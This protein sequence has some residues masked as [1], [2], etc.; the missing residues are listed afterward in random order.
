MKMFLCPK[1]HMDHGPETND[2]ISAEYCQKCVSEM[3]GYTLKELHEISRFTGVAAYM[4]YIPF[5]VTPLPIEE[6]FSI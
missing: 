1:C 6:D 5:Y 4:P 2:G 3:R